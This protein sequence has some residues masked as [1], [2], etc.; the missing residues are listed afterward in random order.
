MMDRSKKTDALKPFALERGR[1]AGPR[2]THRASGAAAGRPVALAWPPASKWSR[3][4]RLRALI[5]STRP[6]WN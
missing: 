2:P 5:A 3:F 4:V 6:L 1:C